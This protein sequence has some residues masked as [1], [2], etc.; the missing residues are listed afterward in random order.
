MHRSA[1]VLFGGGLVLGVAALAWYPMVIPQIAK[2]PTN[3][4]RIYQYEGT[5]VTYLDK[6]TGGTLA[7]PLET[8]LSVDRHVASVAG[9]TGAHTALLEETITATTGDQ[10]VVQKN[11]YAVDR[12]SM[13]NVSDPRAYTLD[14]SNVPDRSGTYYLTFHMGLGKT[15]EQLK[16]WKPEASASYLLT[17][18]DPATGKIDG[19]GVVNLKGQISP[20]LPVSAT[21]MAALKAQGLPTELTPEQ[22][23]ARLTAAGVDIAGVA[24][25]LLQN[26]TAD[27]MKAVTDAMALP[28]PLK[29]FVYGSGSV[30]AEPKTGGMV[31]LAGIIDGVSVKPDMSGMAP[32]L[33][34]L[35]KHQDVP[36][37][38]SLL[39][40]LNKMAAAPAQPVFELRYTQTPASVAEAAKYAKDQASKLSMANTTIPFTLVVV[41]VVLVLL[42]TLLTWLPRRH[43]APV[44]P[45]PQRGERRAA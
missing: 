2:F 11:V 33:A 26:L 42:A 40:T 38:A 34:A 12:R 6:S 8:P 28:V 10:K 24:P 18:T 36:A 35:A 22:A 39:G 14:P 9:A 16:M 13:K 5:M 4:D 20:P 30:A 3:V 43:H 27:E 44:V 19:T 1:R 45:L 7:T 37:I 31:S 41:A 23:T 17:S 32:A 29:Y 15:D 21:E 25:V